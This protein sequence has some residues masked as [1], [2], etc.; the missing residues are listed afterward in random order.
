L[1]EVRVKITVTTPTGNIGSKLVPILLDVPGAEVT[2]LARN[3]QKVEHLAARGV[4]IVAGDQ[5]DPASVDRAVAGADALFWLSA[6]P[7]NATSVRA[8]FNQFADAAAG[9]LRR[10][11]NLHVVQLSSVG[12]QFPEGTGP[13]KGLHDTEHKLSEA[14]KN[15]TYLRA[16]Y[17][18]EN[19]LASL[20]T[21]VSD[22]TIYSVIPGG[23][24]LEHVATADIAAAAA[25]YLLH[26]VP[27]HYIVDVLGPEK[28]SYDYVAEVVGQVIEKPVKHV[29]IPASALKSA[30]L[31][32]GLSEDYAN[33]LVE[34]DQAIATG[35]LNILEGNTTWR[36][37]KTFLE[38]AHEVI[39]PAVKRTIAA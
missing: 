37:K 10:Q 1:T 33:E 36:G 23:V 21:I 14:G 32:A 16:N 25:H 6:V 30:L 17:F 18:M 31:T 13:V 5:L 24:E 26:P 39:A 35:G 2:V 8:G 27:G 38:F 11:P 3:P 19:V 28:I 4:R 7:L 15:V 29:Q 12:A 9:V 22:G 34:L 20:P